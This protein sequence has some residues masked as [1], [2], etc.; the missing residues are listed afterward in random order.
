MFASRAMNFSLL[1]VFFN[2]S[3]FWSSL[4]LVRSLEKDANQ[5]LCFAVTLGATFLGR[6]TLTFRGGF[7]PAIGF[8]DAFPP[9]WNGAGRGACMLD[10]T[11][12]AAEARWYGRLHSITPL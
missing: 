10:A 12:A 3:A 2:S 11:F 1:F 9:A 7:N 8:R 6:C 4:I 5:A